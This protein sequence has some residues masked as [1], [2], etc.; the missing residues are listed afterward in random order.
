MVVVRV[1]NREYWI[2]RMEQLEKARFDTSSKRKNELDRAFALAENHM[3]T[4][5]EYWLNRIAENNE[6]SYAKARQLLKDQELED[7][8]MSLEEY[9]K[10]GKRLKYTDEFAKELENASA[11]YHISRYEAMLLELKQEA[12]R[13][14]AD[15]NNTMDEHLAEMYSET[16]NT[17][18]K[19]FMQST[20]AKVSFSKLSEDTIRKMLDKP[21]TTDNTNYSKK[22]WQNKEKLVRTINREL[23]Q[24]IMRGDDI[25][26]SI[27]IVSDKMKVSRYNAGRLLMTESA[28]IASKAQQDSFKDL[29]VEQ[30]EFV[31]TEDEHTCPTCGSMDGKHWPMNE[32]KIGINVAP[33]HPFCRCTTVPWIYDEED[34]ANDEESDIIKTD[35]QFGKKIGKHTKE[36]GLDPSKQEDREKMNQII[37]DILNNRDEI[38]TGQWRSQEGD[39]DFYIKGNDVVVVNRRREFVTILKEGISNERVKNARKR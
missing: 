6:V 28:A 29:D 39:V 34:V 36:Y 14:H 19:E 33:L 9:I 16:Y 15:I 11:R 37:D 32:Y 30:F 26:K 24:S 10:Q 21:W 20:G 25:K 23:T 2:K 12:E 17:T 5:I 31:A 38:R 13:L 3:R 27:K 18:T 35:K 8:K 1:K 7:F 4:K 22:V